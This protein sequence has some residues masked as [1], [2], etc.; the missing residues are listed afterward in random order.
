MGNVRGSI[1]LGGKSPA[2]NWPG[3]SCPRGNFSDSNYPGGN[4]LEPQKVGYYTTRKFIVIYKMGKEVI[5]FD[6]IE[7][8]KHKFHQHKSPISIWDVNINKII[9]SSKAPFGKN[10]FKNFRWYHKGDRKVT[11]LCIIHPKVRA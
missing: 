3:G 4:V 11:Q 10:C 6:N 8:E 7:V 2:A 1:F 9:V 5:T